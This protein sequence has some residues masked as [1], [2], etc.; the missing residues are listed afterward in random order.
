MIHCICIRWG[1]KYPPIYVNKLYKAITLNTEKEFKFTCFTDLTNSD[2]Y[3][4]QICL[5]KIPVFTGDWYS[6]ISLYNKKLY[7]KEDQIFFFDL[8]TAI[9]SNIDNILDYSGNFAILRDFYHP[10]GFQSAFMSWKPEAVHHMWTSWT[11]DFKAGRGD[12]VWPEIHYPSADIWQI[13]YPEQIIS[14][15]VHIRDKTAKILPKR[16]NLPGNLET[17]KIVCFH[18]KPALH[19]VKQFWNMYDTTQT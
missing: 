11:Q 7:N 19:E 5:E 16:T 12:Q 8:D 18:G 2:D 3:E 13:M 4:P 9:V 1:E 17:A 6:K 14:Y 15:K 10:N